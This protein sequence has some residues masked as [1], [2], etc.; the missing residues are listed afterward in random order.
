MPVSVLM[1]ENRAT[2]SK[3]N[4]CNY[5]II[6]LLYT[7]VLEFHLK[8]KKNM[9]IH[10]NGNH[11]YTADVQYP[12]TPSPH[13]NLIQNPTSFTSSKHSD[14]H[15]QLWTCRRYRK[16]IIFKHNKCSLIVF[17]SHEYA[18]P[19]RHLEKSKQTAMSAMTE[20]G[21]MWYVIG[22]NLRSSRH[23]RRLFAKANHSNQFDCNIVYQ[24]L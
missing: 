11:H 22:G 21:T 7:Y 16:Q 2:C 5:V 23:E 24:C 19:R 8:R 6:N 20:D 10:T 17:L 3:K 14:S 12:H 13:L 15:N 18:C 1:W 9:Y 4:Q